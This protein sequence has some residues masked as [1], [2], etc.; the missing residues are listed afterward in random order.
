MV[1]II[2]KGL[3]TLRQDG[4]RMFVLKTGQFVK[5]RLI[6]GFEHKPVEFVD[7]LFVNGCPLPHPY[8]YRVQHQREQLL[9]YGLSTAEVYMDDLQPELVNHCRTLLLYRCPITP[10]LREFIERAKF[11]NKSVLYDLDDLVIDTK[12]TDMIPYVRQMAPKDKALYD[13]GVHRYHDAMVLCDAVITTTEGLA[14]VF[15]QYVPEVFINRNVASEKMVELS[16]KAVDVVREEKADRN[17]VVMG[18]FSGSITHNDDFAMI[19]PALIHVMEHHANVQLLVVG[20][21]ELPAELEP[22]RERVLV[23]PFV[24]WKKL[25]EL[26]A[27]ADIN[28][29]PLLDTVFNAA[30]SENKWQEAA[31]VGVPTVASRLGAFQRMIHEGKSGLL[32][33][34]LEEWEL[35]LERLVAEP[36]LRERLASRAK[37]EVLDHCV[38]MRTGMGLRNFILRKRNPNLAM[39]FPSFNVSGGV[40]VALKHCDVLREHGYDVTAVNLDQNPG[41]KAEIA[42]GKHEI[43]AVLAREVDF[44][45]RFDKAVATM[46]LTNGVFQGLDLG[47]RYYL[48]QNFETDFYPCGALERFGANST[49]CN[50]FVHYVTISRWCQD[51]LRERFGRDSAYAPNGLERERFYAKPRDWS[52]KIRILIEGDSESKYKNVDE[53]FK[54]VK[55]LNL[56]HYEIWYVSYFGKAKE[57]YHVDKFLHKVAYEKM[58]ELYRSCHIL[59]KTS[60]LESF[61]YPPLEMMATGGVVVARE[62]G[63]NRE[64]LRDK[65]NCLFYDPDDL[66]T[67]VTVIERACEDKMLREKL[68]EGGLR[69]A[70]AREWKN[71]E[72][73]ILA[74]YEANDER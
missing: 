52:G 62:N 58:P 45:S 13:D 10:T 60:I 28:L 46:W 35:A 40:L 73:D 63:G 2:G 21:I 30:K 23:K 57:W 16:A 64:Y 55:Q 26:I 7:V 1:D 18:Y 48:V 29:V 59:L 22:Y 42:Y 20:E 70:D 50:D 15:R 38:T 24:D 31:L 37:A 17:E 67:A 43:S 14:E 34:T 66:S 36:E 33:G 32:C 19:L 5:R 25:P 47:D 11:F 41:A 51:W 3:H 27:S 9:A 53:S 44:H 6:R 12:Y 54:I 68:Y 65:E 49:Y 74:L 72:S 8:R 39:F 56:E 4:L 71:C 69:T 61:S